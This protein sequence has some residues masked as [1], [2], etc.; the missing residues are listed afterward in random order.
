MSR[1]GYT[2]ITGVK[3]GESTSRWAT[4]DGKR[5]GELF[6]IFLLQDQL[7]CRDEVGV[8]SILMTTFVT[9]GLE[10]DGMCSA[11]S[12]TFSATVARRGRK[13]TPPESAHFFPPLERG[14][15]KEPLVRSSY[16]YFDEEPEAE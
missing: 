8:I 7:H 13:K 3:L 12:T 9:A 1:T 4:K 16:D 2:L 15:G 5:L 14:K 10:K 6:L 11:Y